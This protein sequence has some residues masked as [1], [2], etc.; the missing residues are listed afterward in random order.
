MKKVYIF[1]IQA[2]VKAP[3]GYYDHRVVSSELDTEIIKWIVEDAKANE[4]PTLD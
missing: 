3:E 2:L 1:A 4:S